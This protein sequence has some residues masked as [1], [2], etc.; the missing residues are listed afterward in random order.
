MPSGSAQLDF[1]QHDGRAETGPWRC[2]SSIWRSSEMLQILRLFGRDNGELA[3]EVVMLCHE[4][5]V[6]RL[7]APRM[8]S[9]PLS[10]TFVGV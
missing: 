3:V 5:A 1:R 6:L 2:R 10:W 8:S 9:G 4:V 7:W